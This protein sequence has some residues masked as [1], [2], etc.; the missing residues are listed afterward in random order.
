LLN[1]P[2]AICVKFWDSLCEEPSSK[3]L[4][5]KRRHLMLNQT[6]K[7]GIDAVMDFIDLPEL[8]WRCDPRPLSFVRGSGDDGQRMTEKRQK[9]DLFLCR[10]PGQRPSAIINRHHDE[11]PADQPVLL[12]PR[13]D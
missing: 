2:T 4:D 12:Q 10:H 9:I 7:L 1:G 13:P 6:Q 11:P 8:D 3:R 5:W